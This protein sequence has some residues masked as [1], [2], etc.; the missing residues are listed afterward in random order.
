VTLSEL[1]LTPNGKVDR[2]ALPGIDHSRPETVDSYIAPRDMLEFRLARLW[3]ELLP[4]HPIGVRDNFFALGGHS[5]V[6][7]R[8]V[9]R[10][11]QELGKKIPVRAVFQ[12]ATIEYLAGLLREG[13]VKMPRVVQLRSGRKLPFICVH[14]AGGSIFNYLNLA[15]HLDPNQP[16]YALHASGMDEDEPA[17]ETIEAMAADYISAIREEGIKGPYFLGGWS[18]GGVVAFEMA[19]QLRADGE[20]VAGLSLIDS[21][22]PTAEHFDETSLL[23][24]FAQNIGLQA[25]HVDVSPDEL[26]K[27]ST[28]DKLA[29]ILN[30]AKQEHLLPLEVEL[31]DI[32]RSFNVYRANLR[33][34]ANYTPQAQRVRITLF[35][36]DEHVMQNGKGEAMGWDALT[37]EQVEV[38][39]IPGNHYT[40]LSGPHV[41]IL[42]EHLQA[43]FNK[44]EGVCV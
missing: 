36:A 23:I 10:I 1:P 19:R 15:Q 11:E 31:S 3:E 35:K 20:E 40:L 30:W 16:L 4:V 18:M 42:A 39:V 8:L 33:A 14:P 22:V 5:L 26:L 44:A 38:C 24:G 2:K 27:L 21:A 28:E 43:S 6:A 32:Q 29:L 12:G 41:R 25:G 17:H 13:T 37:E 7:V 9:S 34:L